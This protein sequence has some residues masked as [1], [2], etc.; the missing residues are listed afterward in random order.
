MGHQARR[1]FADEA[2]SSFFRFPF[3]LFFGLVFEPVAS[4]FYCYDLGMLEEPVQ[5]GS[6]G[7]DISDKLSPFLYGPVACHDGRA[8][9]VSSHD[10]LEEIFPGTPWKLPEPHVVYYQ[11][12]RLEVF[13]QASVLPRKRVILHELPDQVED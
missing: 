5:D 4:A 12:I 10:D 11:K 2:A 1:S 8:V 7:R 6:G 13:A 9:L 3:P